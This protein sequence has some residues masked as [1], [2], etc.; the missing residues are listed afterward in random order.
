MTVS[1]VAGDISDPM[2]S[3]A[4]AAGAPSGSSPA[5]WLPGVAL[6]LVIVLWG[7]GPPVSKLISA[8]PLVTVTIRFWIS[9]PIL[10][11]MTYAT[12]GRLTTDVLRRTWL[13]GALFGMNLAFVFGSLHHA[14]IAVVSVINALQPGV[15]VASGRLLGERPSRWH[16][17]WTVVGI[18]GAAIVVLGAG[19]K[20]HTSLSGVVLATAAMLTFTGY[21]LLVRHVRS[22]SSITAF[23]WMSGSILFSA[24]TITP[25]ALAFSARSDWGSLTGADWLYLLFVTAAVGI[26]GHAIM[27]WVTRFI[28]ASRSSLYLLAMNVVAVAAAWPIH[29]EPLT[30]MQ[31]LGGLVVLAAVAAVLRRPARVAPAVG[32]AAIGS[33]ASPIRS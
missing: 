33:A 24:I 18:G 20:V 23:E 7:L 28:Q 21:F 5:P 8:P 4:T 15:V 14:S 26:A 11:A 32:S 31:G 27:S 12:G 19:G 30:A 17:L 10:L 25:V 9:V 6:A 2:P 1:R 13:A 3:V 16:L 22:T 29:D